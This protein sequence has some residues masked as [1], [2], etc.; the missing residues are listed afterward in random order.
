VTAPFPVAFNGD[1]GGVFGHG[2]SVD[3]VTQAFGLGG[4][5]VAF[6]G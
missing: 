1:D 5:R 6:N 3:V 2:I 4:S